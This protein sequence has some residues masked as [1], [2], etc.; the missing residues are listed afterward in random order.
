MAFFWTIVLAVMVLML[1]S[2]ALRAAFTTDRRE[3]ILRK[4]EAMYRS[5]KS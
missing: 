5:T 2:Y 1:W 4:L 3:K